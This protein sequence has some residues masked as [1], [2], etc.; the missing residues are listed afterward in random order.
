VVVDRARVVVV[1]GRADDVGPEVAGAAAG[2]TVVLALAV[3]SDT[4]GCR[5]V[6]GADVVA[7]VVDDG[8]GADVVV[9]G[10]ADVLVVDGG[11]EVETAGAEVVDASGSVVWRAPATG[12]VAVAPTV[13][14][15][16]ISRAAPPPRRHRPWTTTSPVLSAPAGRRAAR[17]GR[18]EV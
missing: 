2:R 8:A 3:V 1:A 17:P 10:A 13:S 14:S 16:T 18:S 11:A 9:L 4:A 12:A 6:V 15:D 5:D 7:V